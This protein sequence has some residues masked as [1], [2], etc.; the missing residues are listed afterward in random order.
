MA[1]YRLL[2][3][4]NPVDGSWH[5]PPFED[6]Q[7][8][9]KPLYMA[10]ALIDVPAL[11]GSLETVFVPLVDKPEDTVNTPAT[12]YGAWGLPLAPRNQYV[13]DLR[14]DDKVILYPENDFFGLARRRRW[15]GMLGEMTYTLV[16]YHGH[17][18]SPPVPDTV[19]KSAAADIDGFHRAQVFLRVPRADT[20]GFSLDYAFE[21]PIGA[22]VKL[23][24]AVTPKV[25]YG[26]NSLLSAGFSTD[27]RINSTWKV[28][29]P[30]APPGESDLQ[31]KLH[32]EERHHWA[33]AFRNFSREPVAVS[34]PIVIDDYGL[35]GVHGHVFQ[36]G[37]PERRRI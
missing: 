32:S 6:F 17:Q 16:A 33:M 9:R 24:S 37:G 30:K 21:S 22:V 18:L 27:N 15:K 7:D 34:Q 5:L 1:T 29:D 28:I 11:D 20:Y 12:F 36:S 23:E 19:I 35:P 13:S 26:V 8:I 31:A 2:D 3:S 10:K 14:I 4:I 25:E